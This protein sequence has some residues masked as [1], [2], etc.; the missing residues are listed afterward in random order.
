MKP[1]FP[2]RILRRGHQLKCLQESKGKKKEKG[3]IYKHDIHTLHEGLIYRDIGTVTWFF[4]LN[5]IK[6]L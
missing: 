1:F 6:Q 2:F 3:A 5:T 4:T